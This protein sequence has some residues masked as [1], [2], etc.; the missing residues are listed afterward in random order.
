MSID[1]VLQAQVREK[2]LAPLDWE[3]SMFQSPLVEKIGSSLKVDLGG[4]LVLWGPNDSGKSYALRDFTKKCQ[5]E[6]EIVK[7]LDGSDCRAS[8]FGDWFFTSI[9]F[10]PTKPF[11][12]IGSYCP[13]GK[14]FKPIFLIDHLEDLLNLPDT[15]T[16][17]VQLARFS[18]EKNDFKVLVCLSHLENTIGVLKWNGGTKIR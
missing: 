5:C 14:E 7:Y 12:N 13:K 11:G 17:I 4:V 6:G 16:T 10:D 1:V 18:K 15:Q 2:M 3:T 9:G 8:C